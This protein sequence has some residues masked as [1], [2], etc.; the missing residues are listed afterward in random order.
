MKKTLRLLG[1]TAI[2]AIIGFGFAS[3]EGPAGSPGPQGQIGPD[4]VTI[5][6]TFGGTGVAFLY[7]VGRRGE[8]FPRTSILSFGN[9]ATLAAAEAADGAMRRTVTIS[10]EASSHT[11]R[12]S[13]TLSGDPVRYE[14][15]GGTE[16]FYLGPRESR[17]IVIV[18]ITTGANA[19][20]AGINHTRITAAIT[21]DWFGNVNRYLDV[22]FGM[23]ADAAAFTGGV[24]NHITSDINWR[25]LPPQAWVPGTDATLTNNALF[26]A[27]GAEVTRVIGLLQLPAAAVA[28]ITLTTAPTPPN[29]SIDIHGFEETNVAFTVPVGGVSVPVI[30]PVTLQP[31]ITVTATGGTLV[32]STLTINA[33][34]TA[35]TAV[36]TAAG[37]AGVWTPGVDGYAPP[38]DWVV[39][40]GSTA[41][42]TVP[43]NHAPADPTSPFR[44]ILTAAGVARPITVIVVNAPTP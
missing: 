7:D 17:D 12:I 38:T 41:T 27:V 5:G 42:I 3:C 23:G 31:G 1:I 8:G 18:P 19:I 4:G 21:S 13:L 28:G 39:I 34:T 37:A 22:F 43:A 20:A 24:L 14:I 25:P 6:V 29:P 36:L 2:A 16:P 35:V 32:G 26:T 11:K 9:H 10:N 15:V 30:V 33:A 40:E 44:V